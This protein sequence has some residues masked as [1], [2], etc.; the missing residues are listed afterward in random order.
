MPSQI[1][2][3]SPIPRCFLPRT[4]RWNSASRAAR[5]SPARRRRPRRRA[6]R[7][8]ARHAPRRA[9]PEACGARVVEQVVERLFEQHGVGVDHRQSG[10]DLH[11][12]VVLLQ[13]C[14]PQRCAD[15][16]LEARPLPAQLDRARL[17]P[18]R[19]HEVGDQVLEPPG[20]GED[21]RRQLVARGPV[22]ACGP[23]DEAARGAGDGRQRRAQVVRHRRQQR[24]AQAFGLDL[25]PHA[26]AILGDPRRSSASCG[27]LG[28]RVD[29][30]APRGWQRHVAIPAAGRRAPPPCRARE[31]RQEQ[32]AGARQVAGAG[33]GRP[34]RDP[35]TSAPPPACRRRSSP[36]PVRRDERGD[37]RWA[38]GRAQRRTPR[39]RR[40]RRR[41]G[42]PTTIRADL[43][44]VRA[45]RR[46]R[47][48]ATAG[49]STSLRDGRALHG[50]FAH[51]ATT[52]ADGDADDAI[53]GEREQVGR[54][55]IAKVNRGSTNRKLKASAL[56]NATSSDGQRPWRQ[57]GRD[58]A[59]HQGQRL[60][61]QVRA[62]S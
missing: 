11:G 59:E 44:T 30:Q 23:V 5:G 34:C 32:G 61:R 45:H 4:K 48:S 36:C 16:F 17:E 43:S 55:A 10:G 14:S 40:A 57:R 49:R 42:G 41:A 12:D 33:T 1:A 60:G 9:C 29:Q 22:E 35:C 8:A 62:R 27:L 7:P 50:A 18:R 39:G 19:E 28:E 20:L 15:D 6:R 54:S 38:R 56:T 3:P 37:G 47:A 24:A 2:S 52:S 51:A 21:R 53:D 46:V 13:R 58:D 26:L 31:Q 25:L